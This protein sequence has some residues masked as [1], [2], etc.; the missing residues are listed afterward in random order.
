MVMK[1]KTIH[2]IASSRLKDKGTCNSCA[3]LGSWEEYGT[4]HAE[5]LHSLLGKLP[6]TTGKKSW[7]EKTCPYPLWEPLNYKFCDKHGFYSEKHGCT[8]CEY[9][10]YKDQI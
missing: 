3:Y 10:Y 5:C 7:G 2:E 9:E 1:L 4:Y 8:N 6:G